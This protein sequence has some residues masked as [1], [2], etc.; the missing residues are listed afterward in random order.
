M[1][2][3]A[4]A[5]SDGLT[6]DLFAE[7]PVKNY[8]ESLAWFNKLLGCSPAF[9]PTDTEAVWKLAEHRYFFIKVLPE[10]SGH[11]FNLVFI[12]NFDEFV[13]EVSD[14]GIEPTNKETLPNGVRKW[15]YKDPSGNEIGF[16][17]QPE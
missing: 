17:G 6:I 10:H 15:T 13:G 9:Y 8:E 14:R 3:P 4:A 1:D 7:F 16:G 11:A 12:S 5:F 2:E